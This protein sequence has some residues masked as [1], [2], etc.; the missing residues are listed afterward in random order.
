MV[1]VWMWIA[2]MKNGTS[3]GR[4]WKIDVRDDDQ[5]FQKSGN[6]V[7]NSTERDRWKG[8]IATLVASDE[9]GPRWAEAQ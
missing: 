7:W 8:A 3:N 2:S 6:N 5:Y 9:R 4:G 1:F